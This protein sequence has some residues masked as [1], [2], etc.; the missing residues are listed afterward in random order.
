MLMFCM[1]LS[2]EKNPVGNMAVVLSDWGHSLP[3]TRERFVGPGLGVADSG[4]KSQ[5][6]FSSSFLGTVGFGPLLWIG[7][8]SW[9]G[10]TNR[11]PCELETKRTVYQDLWRANPSLKHTS[12]SLL[13]DF[14]PSD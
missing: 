3:L 1:P 5:C 6:A 2:R 12:L 11:T 14:L 13:G 9:G 10:G 7:N 4:R 8:L